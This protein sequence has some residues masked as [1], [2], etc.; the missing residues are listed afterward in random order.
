[1]YQSFGCWCLNLRAC[2]SHLYVL[3]WFILK[4][5][6]LF[7][8]SFL[9]SFSELA[10]THYKLCQT[11][12]GFIV[13][14]F[15]TLAHWGG[16]LFTCGWCGCVYFD[17]VHMHVYVCVRP[18]VL[19]HYIW[20]SS[21]GLG[22]RCIPPKRKVFASIRLL[23]WSYQVKDHFKFSAWFFCCCLCN[24]TSNENSPGKPGLSLWVYRGT[25]FFLLASWL[26]LSLGQVY[27]W[28]VVTPAGIG[29]GEF[30]YIGGCWLDNMP[31]L[32]LNLLSYVLHIWKQWQGYQVWHLLK[33]WKQMDCSAP[34]L[35]FRSSFNLVLWGFLHHYVKDD[36]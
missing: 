33:G 8:I 7:I 15:L 11:L 17:C 14:F 10:F 27:F 19:W 31:S 13:L 32:H 21:W 24:Y 29:I 34:I 9:Y 36:S 1:M 28:F 20:K 30:R 25:L 3:L 4:Y 6:L 23:S 5:T 12:P 22:R 26:Y 16:T 18:W 35:D 2:V